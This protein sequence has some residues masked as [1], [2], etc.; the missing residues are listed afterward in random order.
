MSQNF[1]SKQNKI[2]E[3]KWEV[4]LQNF[5]R[6]PMT[7]SFWWIDDNHRSFVL[8]TLLQD[9]IKKETWLLLSFFIC[10]HKYKQAQMFEKGDS[11]NRQKINGCSFQ[12]VLQQNL[13]WFLPQ[14]R[15]TFFRWGFT[16]KP[17]ERV[18]V[19]LQTGSWDFQNSPPFGRST[20]F[21][22]AII[23][24]FQGFQYFKFETNFLKNENLFQ[25][26]GAPF[27]SWKY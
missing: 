27:F 12:H 21:Y 3:H 1:W 16:L 17:T 26:T 11:S 13:S 15:K 20:C 5:S 23:E 6:K 9:C 22:V 19:L 2:N 8:L 25:K 14:H 24:N 10:L 18:Q 4:S 7:C